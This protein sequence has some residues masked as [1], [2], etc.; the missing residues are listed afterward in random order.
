MF[1]SMG[2]VT[3]A[4]VAIFIKSTMVLVP[5]LLAAAL[6]KRRTAAFRH[7]LLSFALIGLLLVPVSSLIPFGWRTSLL[8]GG[9]SPAV[10]TMPPAQAGKA[11]AEIDDDFVASANP[12]PAAAF[13]RNSNVDGPASAPK[14]AGGLQLGPFAVNVA[15]GPA[16][17]SHGF[18]KEGPGIAY[19]F[20][21]VQRKD[22]GGSVENPPSAGF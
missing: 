11:A 17:S 10:K 4:V 6:F 21:P 15:K 22:N 1:Q 14:T 16:L 5:A 19:I 7:F 18:K 20:R 3:A 12:D 13:S 9:S 8:P 2:P